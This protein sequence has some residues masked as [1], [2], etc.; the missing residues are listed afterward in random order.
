MLSAPS[1]SYGDVL[2]SHYKVKL[3]HRTYIVNASAYIV[4]ASAY[5]VNASTCIVNASTCAN[6][7]QRTGKSNFNC[8]E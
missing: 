6:V 3:M 2:R 1:D 7:I 4:N 8:L 5:I